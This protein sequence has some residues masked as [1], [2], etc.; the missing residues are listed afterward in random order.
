M[1]ETLDDELI[2][3]QRRSWEALGRCLTDHFEF[4]SEHK[5]EEQNLR[6]LF[7]TA[8]EDLLNRRKEIVNIEKA[9]QKHEHN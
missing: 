8:R 5:E 3:Q 6:K 1:Y 4:D 2:D 9:R 7:A